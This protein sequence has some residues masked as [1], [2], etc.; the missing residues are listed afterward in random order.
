MSGVV[1]PILG[2]LVTVLAAISFGL[3]A[4]DK[5]GIALRGLERYVLAFVTG[6]ACL[7]LA[8]MLLAA[9]HLAR[10]G[11]FFALAAALVILASHLDRSAAR[12]VTRA[13]RNRI[14][15]WWRH[16]FQ[17]AA[18]GASAVLA[19]LRFARKGLLVALAAALMTLAWRSERSAARNRTA[20]G[21]YWA[22]AVPSWLVWLFVALTIPF[23]IW[24]LVVAWAPEVS[25]DGSTYHLGNVFRFWA[26]HGLTPI[27]DMYGA[28]PEGME[29]L[30][31]MAFSIGR[32]SAAA[33]VHLSF[34]I[35]L[36]LLVVSYSLRFGFPKA[37]FLAAVLVFASP[38]IA[39]DGSEAYNDVALA[40]V[41]FGVFYATELWIKE[42]K[43][44]FLVVAGVLAG[45]CFDIK[46][47]GFVAAVYAL[48]QVLPRLVRERRF[49]WRTALLF[50]AP[51]AIMVAPWL[52]KNAIYMD[53]PLS[54]FFNGLF[55]NPY[56]SPQFE[57]EYS[58]A[59]AAYAGAAN[60]RDLAFEYT[61][62]GS[63]VS[64]FLGPI[65]LLA[66]LGLFLLRL[67]RGRRLLL[68]AVLF[69]LPIVFNTGTRFLIPAAPCL[70]L[71]IA[72]AVADTKFAVPA[73]MI[74]HAVASWPDV[75]DTYCDRYAPRIEEF[76][77]EAVLNSKAALEYV[78][79][80]LGSGWDMAQIVD[81]RIPNGGRIYCYSC[82]A[83]A[84]TLHDISHYYETLESRALG[85][86]LWTP[87]ETGRQPLKHITLSFAPLT[88][89]RLRVT[90]RQSR[91]DEV[92][93]V[94]EMRILR[95]G[96]EIPRSARWKISASP[97]P[98]EAPFAFDNNAVS[99]WSVEQ[100]GASGA[101]LEVAFD[102]PTA[103]DSVLLECL[104]NAPEQVGVE[105]ATSGGLVQVKASLHAA[106]V[107]APTG[108][109]RSAIKMLERYGFEYLMIS[110]SGYY[111]DDY[112][113]YANFW[114]IRSVAESG[115]TILYH[116][117]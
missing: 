22:A 113:K 70:A 17:R 114:G 32:H 83:Q 105:A 108:L 43:G 112:K 49:H 95:E 86:M 6:S 106:K 96:R 66:P 55:P 44:H 36:P 100:F 79:Q 111:A 2:A 103:V 98:W 71:A 90:L 33:L 57:R 93:S 94:S 67:P 77:I 75:A 81:R 74:I 47:T 46:Y 4:F 68:A 29:M 99:K 65:F 19:A 38:I 80:K 82:P 13:G 12:L 9:L 88:A 14:T 72:T 16:V 116:L 3:L 1:S 91:P 28:L 11:V 37:G 62:T 107:E 69:G 56:N 92:W 10:K 115:D 39:K 52:V 18:E 15:K 89:T 117:E 31:L 21:A 59:M 101:F 84:Y 61:V 110:N 102:A 97:D 53:N 23:A 78:H 51:C 104:E 40:A 7:S 63:S 42:R 85:D 41:S 24:Y 26:H 5:L 20:D 76:P 50:A 34:L 64:G 25:A 48:S 87:M 58:Q 60:I 45:F 109:R 30:F 54:P 27:R 35:C 73:L 8:A